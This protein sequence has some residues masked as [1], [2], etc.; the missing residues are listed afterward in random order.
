MTEK[1]NIDPL[2]AHDPP[3]AAAD[4]THSGAA[5]EVSSAMSEYVD[6]KSLSLAVCLSQRAVGNEKQRDI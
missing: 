1:E 5:V 6:E 3:L 4:E 2:L